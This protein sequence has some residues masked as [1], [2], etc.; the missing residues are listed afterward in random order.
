[1]QIEQ[2]DTNMTRTMMDAFFSW[3]AAH[4]LSRIH[5]IVD[6]TLFDSKAFVDDM[7]GLYQI[8]LSIGAAAVRGF[9]YHDH[10]FSY[11]CMRQGVHIDMDIPYEAVL[12]FVIPTGDNTEVIFEVPNLERHMLKI[13]QQ[14]GQLPQLGNFAFVDEQGKALPDEMIQEIMRQLVPTGV[15]AKAIEPA[16]YAVHG[17]EPEVDTEL[18]PTITDLM[19]RRPAVQRSAKPTVKEAPAPLLNFGNVSGTA[20]PAPKVKRAIP[21]GW[22]VIQ[23]GR[24]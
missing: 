10:G 22:Q 21:E 11:G 8:R 17:I 7:N 16:P 20:L 3:F 19:T 18:H 6:G 9:A 12:G 23:G 13:E 4:D 2:R 24:V 1:M 5:V 15:P 14:K